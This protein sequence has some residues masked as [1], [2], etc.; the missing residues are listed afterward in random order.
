MFWGVFVLLAL[1]VDST[2]N[3]DSTSS[4]DSASDLSRKFELEVPN[5]IRTLSADEDDTGAKHVLK[6]LISSFNY[7]AC[8]MA[9]VKLP[10]QI[11]ATRMRKP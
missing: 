9:Q 11:L 10:T 7:R 4:V 8:S 1:C 6:V 3:L 2:V 5:S